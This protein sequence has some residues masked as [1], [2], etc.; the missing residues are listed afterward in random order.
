MEN[1]MLLLYRKGK[2]SIW[3]FGSTSG[4]S[5]WEFHVYGLMRD[6]RVCPSL[7]MACELLGIDPRPILRKAPFLARN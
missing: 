3:A 6:P 1:N 5:A 7:S 2:Y 4:P